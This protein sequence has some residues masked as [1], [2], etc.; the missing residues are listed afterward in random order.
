MNPELATNFLAG[1]VI[2]CLALY[3]GWEFYKG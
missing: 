1:S 3:V 2:L